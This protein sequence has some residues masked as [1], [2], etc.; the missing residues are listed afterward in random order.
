[1]L[2]PLLKSILYNVLKVNNFNK[3]NETVYTLI[4]SGNNYNIWKK[5]SVTVF[6]FIKCTVFEVDLT[7]S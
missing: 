3:Y 5:Q 4:L 1:M 7:N 2:K 6:T